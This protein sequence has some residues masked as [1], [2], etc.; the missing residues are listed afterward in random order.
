M[1]ND[2]SMNQLLRFVFDFIFKELVRSQEPNSGILP[3]I[4]SYY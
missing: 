2:M 3:R 4:K 1:G